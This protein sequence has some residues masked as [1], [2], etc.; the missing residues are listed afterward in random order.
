MWPLSGS[1]EPTGG[2]RIVDDLAGATPRMSAQNTLTE[3]RSTCGVAFVESHG[4][5]VDAL[6]THSDS[7]R[8]VY[9]TPS[10]DW[11]R[12]TWPSGN[13]V[14]L[15][16]R[17]SSIS[18]LARL[19]ATLRFRLFR[20]R[21]RPPSMVEREAS[22]EDREDADRDDQLDHG[23]AALVPPGSPAGS[24]S[25]ICTRGHFGR[26]SSLPPCIGK[27]GPSP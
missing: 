13:D 8:T 23:E 7:R 11:H 26:I 27:R 3:T 17:T 10:T 6:S 5:V 21:F 12:S 18:W 20:A 9:G 4:P 15:A 25:G 14:K 2:L 22:G 24:A 19:A 1:Y 16:D